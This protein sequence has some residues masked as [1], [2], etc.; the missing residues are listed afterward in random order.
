MWLIINNGSDSTWSTNGYFVKPSCSIKVWDN[1]QSGNVLLDTR[2]ISV[3]NNSVDIKDTFSWQIA[4]YVVCS[5]VLFRY[6]LRIFWRGLCAI[7]N[8][9]QVDI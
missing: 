4:F 9:R 1:S 7:F 3:S 2:I 6:V 5:I 8:V